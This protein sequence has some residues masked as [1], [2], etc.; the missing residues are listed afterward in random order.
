MDLVH[1][2]VAGMIS[3]EEDKQFGWAGGCRC[4]T[5]SVYQRKQRVLG[6]VDYQQRTADVASD[7]LKDELSSQ[8]AGF[9]LT[10]CARYANCRLRL[11][12]RLIA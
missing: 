11:E 8:I 2:V 10:G 1:D 3:F 6:P 12:P 5:L 7:G 9:G 4:Q